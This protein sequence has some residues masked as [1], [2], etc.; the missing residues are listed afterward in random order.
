MLAATDRHVA[1]SIIVRFN[2][3]APFKRLTMNKSKHEATPGHQEMQMFKNHS[4]FR[5]REEAPPNPTRQRTACGTMPTMEFASRSPRAILKPYASPGLFITGT[6]TDVGKTMVTAA[7]A[8][9]FH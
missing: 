9:A 6:G 5:D 7:L 1:A 8:A 2:I 3:R 4:R